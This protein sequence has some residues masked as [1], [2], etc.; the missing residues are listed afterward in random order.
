MDNL[1]LQSN[2][3]KKKEKDESPKKNIKKYLSIS[4]NN[5]YSTKKFGSVIQQNKNIYLDINKLLSKNHK[6]VLNPSLLTKK[7][8]S[9]NKS[10]ITANSLSNSNIL[11]KTTEENLIQKI[12]SNEN[13][14]VKTSLKNLQKAISKRESKQTINKL[15]GKVLKNV[16]KFFQKFFNKESEISEK[17]EDTK[18]KNKSSTKILNNK[19]IEEI[20][21][22][23]NKLLLNK[24]RK[25][26]IIST[27]ISKNPNLINDASKRNSFFKFGL[28]TKK[29]NNLERKSMQI[30]NNVKT[31]KRKK[32]SI[33]S[34][35]ENLQ[36]KT[37]QKINSDIS[38]QIRKSSICNMQEIK[39]L[40][41]LDI[42][43]LIEKSK[44]NKKNE[45]AMKRRKSLIETNFNFDITKIRENIKEEEFQNRFRNLFLC[46]NLY[47][48]LDDDENENL[49]LESAFFIG[50]N[51][52]LCYIIDTMTLIISLFCLIY[53]PYFLAFNLNECKYNFYSGTFMFFLFNDLIYFIDLIAGFFRAYYNF[54]E[55]LIFKKRYM[56]LNYLKGW[57]IFDLIEAIPYLMILNSGKK[58]CNKDIS[59][60]F[61][62][63]D[64]LN[65]SFLLLK[66][67]KVFK[68][69]KNSAIKAMDKFLSKSNFFSDWKDVFKYVIIILCALHIASCYFIFLGNNVYPGWFAEGLQ[70]ESHKDIYI[71][72]IYYLITTLTTVGYGDIN[73]HS[74]YQRLFQILLLIVGTLS[75]SWLLTYISNYIKKNNEKYI[76]YE[77]KVKILE[78]I[79]IN[80]PNLSNNLY[81]RIQ[82]YL[83]Y[84]KSK[85]KYNIKY[86]LDSLPASIQNN[87]IIEIY[88][89]IIKN[90]L[91]FK[92]FENSDFFVK[93]VTSMKPILSM[94]D[95]ILVHEGDVIED[96]I[97]IK[98]GRLS[99]EVDINLDGPKNNVEENLKTSNSI[100]KRFDTLSY[101]QS[102]NPSQTKKEDKDKN[103]NFSYLDFTTKKS[104][105]TFKFEKKQC[106]KKQLKI[107]EL[108]KNEHFGDVLMILNEKSPVTIKVKSKKAELLFLQKTDATEIS[109]LY[110]NIWKRIATKSCHNLTEIKNIIKKK[111]KLYCELNDI[112]LD[113]Q[114]QKNYSENNKEVKFNI[115]ENNT[116]IKKRK[117]SNNKY[118]KSI[119]K[120]VDESKYLSAKNSNISKKIKGISIKSDDDEEEKE[121]KSNEKEE[122]VNS[123][124]KEN[125]EEK[126]NSEEKEKNNDMTPIFNE[127]RKKNLNNNTNITNNSEQILNDNKII[128]DIILGLNQNKI[129]SFFE[130][131]KNINKEK[132]SNIKS[133]ILNCNSDIVN[134]ANKKKIESKLNNINLNKKIEDENLE[135]V[136]EEMFFNEEFGTNIINRKISMNNYDKNNYIFHQISKE[137]NDEL[138][139]H[140]N[141]FD[142]IYKLLHDNNISDLNIENVLIDNHSVH[143]DKGNKKINIYNNIVINNSHKNDNAINTNYTKKNSFD[144]LENTSADSF[145]INSTYENINKISKYKY[146]SD[147]SLQFKIKKLLIQTPN[148]KTYKTIQSTKDNKSTLFKDET[149]SSKNNNFKTKSMFY[150]AD[151]NRLDNDKSPTNTHLVKHKFNHILHE[152]DN[153]TPKYSRESKLRS[154]INEPEEDNFYTMVKMNNRT[155]RSCKNIE[156]SRKTNNYEDK[157]SKN[158]EINKQNLNNPKEYFSGLFNKIL[159]KKQK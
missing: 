139:T 99:L 57:F 94:K 18:P 122:K 152:S 124:E 48:S 50:P 85:Y 87:L 10:S 127:K 153:D 61:A 56:C 23:K 13:T 111:V 129:N 45:P 144:K 70:S 106:Q 75:Y 39:K 34:Q 17:K 114:F 92:Y 83:R 71:A 90:F 121:N 47:D 131:N 116:Q 16:I 97:F 154:S 54:E 151:K 96:I 59:H 112:P 49:E 103:M 36:I 3:S 126:E 26:A 46:D 147:K 30:I 52:A 27:S 42:T 9:K 35:R 108:R 81:E 6:T 53:T 102:I 11:L 43:D 7:D 138:I 113:E 134:Q 64:N 130:E 51:D 72:S 118:I 74:K 65:Y 93:I 5:D 73:V 146:A 80:Y 100:T 142:K 98:K 117:N 120:E 107:I 82:R 136:N 29:T 135:R 77:E 101:F 76:V 40:E 143:S 104:N 125:N 128:S 15:E 41:T 119:I 132:K 140:N 21:K 78:E 95:D 24:K 69:F 84:N 115:D 38:R 68:T 86:V 44:N 60:N 19:L 89:P 67:F 158:I 20:E 12:N 22:E 55:V 88:K 159:T 28:K 1:L 110:P 66:I 148:F 31:P 157:I 33:F 109:N 156:K 145:S 58:F 2:K 149:P 150:S 4:S 91:F 8:S 32:I 62:Y 123:E 105:T 63:G 141:S 155:K 137:K 37:L 79:K 14:I 25:S 133:N